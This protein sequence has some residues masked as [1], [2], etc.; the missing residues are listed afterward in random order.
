M[1]RILLSIGVILVSIQLARSDVPNRLAFI[2]NIEGVSSIYIADPDHSDVTL[3]GKLKLNDGIIPHWDL[4]F[5]PDRTKVMFV[6]SYGMP[7]AL[8]LW[9]ANTDGTGLRKL[10]DWEWLNQSPFHAA[11]SPSGD[12]IAFVGGKENSSWIY[13]VNPDGSDLHSVGEGDYFSWSP[14]GTQLAFTGFHLPRP[15]RFVYVVNIDG[16]N[17]RQ[18]AS[19]SVIKCSWSPDGKLV[20]FHEYHPERS[21]S[22][23]L[24]NVF[25]IQ[26]D[27]SGKKSVLEKVT[28]YSSPVWSPRGEFL[29]FLAKSEG[30]QGLYIWAASQQRLRFFGGVGGPFDWSPDGRQIAFGTVAGVKLLDIETAATKL[31]FHTTGFSRPLWFQDGK[32]LLLLQNPDSNRRYTSDFSELELWTT[33]LEPRF[34]TKVTDEAL[35]VTDLSSPP[36]GTHIAFETATGT[37]EKPEPGPVYVVN[38][39][40]S[41]LRKLPVTAIRSEWFAW[42]PDGTRIAF[43]K[44]ISPTSYQI[45]IANADGSGAQILVDGPSANFAPAWQPDGKN[46]VFISNR[47][48]SRA[49]YSI[50]VRTKRMRRVVDI[51]VYIYYSVMSGLRQPFIPLLWS[52]DVTKFAVQMFKTI[53]IIDITKQADVVQYHGFSPAL[54]SWT[55]DS[56]RIVVVDVP[57]GMRVIGNAMP[58][59][60]YFEVY[61]TDGKIGQSHFIPA[62]DQYPRFPSRVA[63]R[64]DGERLAA[65]DRFGGIWV[66]GDQGPDQRRMLKGSQAIWV[67]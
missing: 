49:V 38:P 5:S 20:A 66:I 27:G 51:P 17:L 53:A 31:L 40:G 62:R 63:W 39:D 45:Y 35:V 43:V 54:Q 16:S 32:R 50:N 37:A 19:G 18:I 61:A 55:P 1:K 46:I 4:V 60:D 26:P 59:Y 65:S 64:S 21:A 25:V 8:A 23:P 56:Q 48:N 67:R 13:I 6:A 24:Y 12:R 36:T 58:S 29:S 30:S 28:L 34:I 52:P 22:L 42:S 47:E 33:N 41:R 3:R 2:S 7:R 11:W 57:L 15:G 9:I 10:I 14:D 44:E